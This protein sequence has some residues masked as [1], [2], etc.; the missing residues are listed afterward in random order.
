[1]VTVTLEDPL[2]GRC[3]DLDLLLADGD[4]A[5]R[6]QGL[7]Q[8]MIIRHIRGILTAEVAKSNGWSPEAMCVR[9]KD[10]TFDIDK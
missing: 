8:G 4:L 6:A 3:I 10:A 7:K 9:M 2:Y 5:A 1:M